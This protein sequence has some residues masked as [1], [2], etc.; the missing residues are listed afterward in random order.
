MSTSDFPKKPVE[1]WTIPLHVI[2]WTT[3]LVG[4]LMVMA[5][6]MMH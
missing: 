5:V 1:A 2:L 3:L 6:I 4:L